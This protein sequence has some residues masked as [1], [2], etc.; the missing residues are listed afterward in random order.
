[1]GDIEYFDHQLDV[2][3]VFEPTILANKLVVRQC[4]IYDRI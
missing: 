1:M 3:D 2:F 4:R